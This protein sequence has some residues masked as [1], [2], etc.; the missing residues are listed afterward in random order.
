VFNAIMA[1]ALMSFAKTNNEIGIRILDLWIRGF[2]RD[3]S[4]WRVIGKD[5]MAG[6]SDV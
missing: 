4:H 5:R 1:P 3:P 2:G 6:T